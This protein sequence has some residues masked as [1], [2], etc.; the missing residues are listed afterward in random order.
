MTS[1]Q[2][3]EELVAVF[4]IGS[5]SVGG[6]LVLMPKGEPAKS[7][8]F[9]A[10]QFE[11]NKKPKPEILFTA[12]APIVFGPNLDFEVFLFE[13]SK[14][15]ETV[16]SRLLSARLGAPKKAYCFLAAPWC[17]TQT[18]VIKMERNTPFIL[19]DKLLSDLSCREIKAFEEE[20]AKRYPKGEK[21]R[22]LEGE[23]MQ[24]KLNG[25]KTSDPYGKKTKSLEAALFAS[26]GS[27][28]VLGALEYH[29]GK[30]FNLD[31]DSRI[32]EYPRLWN[33]S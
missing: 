28:Q 24:V 13:M 17:A 6:A 5:G 26:I 27:E 3:K 10:L 12:R 18:R 1:S 16:A 15:L 22:L 23:I 2:K 25:Y 14:A 33:I 32:A 8:D 20:N 7:F 31:I 30:F 29:I 4:D 21:I 19:T 9:L 11:E